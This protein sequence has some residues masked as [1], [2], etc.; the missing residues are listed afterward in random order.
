SP[1]PPPSPPAPIPDNSL[2]GGNCPDA[3][4]LLTAT[5]K[6]RAIHQAP[7]LTWDANLAAR[8]Q[9][10]AN[11]LVTQKC[12]MIH[13]TVGE[14]LFGELS[15]PW[16]EG[17]CQDAV[18]N[19]YSE[20][21]NYDFNVPRPFFDNYF[22]NEIGHFTQLVWAST[23]TIGCG[24]AVAAQPVTFSSGNVYTG[25]CKVVVCRYNPPGN[26]ADDDL[27]RRNVLPNTTAIPRL[28]NLLSVF[29]GGWE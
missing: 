20:V 4:L 3:S 21:G 14:N 16:P 28:R 17:V 7:P 22:R 25:A 6:Y 26:Y 12:V 9:A 1:Q 10:Y 13:G 18:D 2:P 29:P 27:T 5:N 23:T 19:W 8:S 24:F 15:Y 11:W